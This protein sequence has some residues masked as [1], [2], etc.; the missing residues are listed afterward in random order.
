MSI[1]WIM[2]NERAESVL[3]DNLW[4]MSVFLKLSCFYWLFLLEF[5]LCSAALMF[6]GEAS[7]LSVLQCWC[8]CLWCGWRGGIRRGRPSSSSSTPRMTSGTTSSNMMRRGVE[9]RTRYE[10]GNQALNFLNFLLKLT[11]SLSNCH[12]EQSECFK[13]ASAVFN[14]LF[15]LSALQKTAFSGI[16]CFLLENNFM[17][18]SKQQSS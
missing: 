10:H 12:S 2:T 11:L 15:R 6:C 7:I 16:N 8:C 13:L 4:I 3:L 9:K 17:H 1:T 18:L 5:D 14:H